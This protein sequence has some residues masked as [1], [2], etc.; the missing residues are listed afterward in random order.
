[1]T[2][3]HRG[4]RFRRWLGARFGG[5]E[6]LGD[7]LWRRGLHLLGPAVLLYVPFPEEIGGV[8]PK[9]ALLLGT[10]VVVVV[11]ELLRHLGRVELPG[12]RE[13]ERGRPA[14]FVFYATALVVAVLAFPLPIAAA[15]VFGTAWVDPLIGELRGTASGRRAYPLLPFAVWVGL[16]LGSLSGIGGWPILPAAAVALPAGAVALV[17]ERPKLRWMDD[18]LAMTIVPA[19]VL[20]G[21]GVLVLGR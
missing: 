12:M 5:D 21:L 13:Y 9:L 15:V 1:M 2:R 11:L 8:V 17:V 14:S 7:R 10:Y 20:Y 3:L 16:A 19:V 4:G 18:D 6:A